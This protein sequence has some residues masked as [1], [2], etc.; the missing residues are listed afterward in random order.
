[1][2][3]CVCVTYI[4]GICGELYSSLLGDVVAWKGT[5]SNTEYIKL[6]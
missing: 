3:V 5:T 2:C 1:M 6:T 4:A